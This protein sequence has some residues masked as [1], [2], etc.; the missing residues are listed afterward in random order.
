MN[1]FENFILKAENEL[2]ESKNSDP[3]G[4]KI[5]EDLKKKG[6]RIPA[7]LSVVKKNLTTSIAY[8]ISVKDL[9]IRKEDVMEIVGKYKN[10]EVD[11]SG[12]ILSGGNTFINVSY[13]P[14]VVDKEMKRLLPKCVEIVDKMMEKKGKS[15]KLN[16]G[17]EVVM[18][19]TAT[20]RDAEDIKNG[21]QSGNRN[22]SVIRKGEFVSREF[23]Y[24]LWEV[25]ARLGY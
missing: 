19:S 14:K 24:G 5:K 17:Y 15:V 25:L 23:E 18:M 22:F 9:K 7:Q 21:R 2:E 4:D 10:Y 16:N 8:N 20:D 6:Y 1:I 11:A 12:D 13:D 3:I